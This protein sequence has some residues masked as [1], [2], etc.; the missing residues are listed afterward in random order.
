MAVLL[1][2]VRVDLSQVLGSLVN[3]HA[4][5]VA[6]LTVGV[7]GT[8][9][10]DA[11]PRYFDVAGAGQG[12]SGGQ[13]KGGGMAGFHGQ[14]VGAGMSGSRLVGA[15][16][17]DQTYV[18]TGNP[19]YRKGNGRRGGAREGAVPGAGVFPSSGGN[20]VKF[21][22]ELEQDGPPAAESGVGVEAPNGAQAGPGKTQRD[23]IIEAVEV[24]RLLLGQGVCSKLE[25]LIQEHIPP[26]P[27][28]T[29]SPFSY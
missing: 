10:T 9:A 23:K 15:L 3:G 8:V 17:R 24:L 25:D 16:G 21:Q 26:L 27:K 13:G 18:S 29:P 14:G 2:W 11:G 22:G 4:P 28:V 1:A 19:S 5:T 12:H 7:R 6:N 20:R